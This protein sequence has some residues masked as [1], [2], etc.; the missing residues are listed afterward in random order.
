MKKKHS[1]KEKNEKNEKHELSEL[2][3]PYGDTMNDGVVQLSFTLPVECGARAK[4]AA[5]LYAQKLNFSEV[6]IAH[7]KKIADGF[8]YFVIYGKAEP[9]LDYSKVQATEVVTENLNF[10]TINEMIKNRLNRPLVVVGATIGSDAHTVGIDAIMNM[11]GYNQDYGLERY[12][13]MRAYN[14]GAQ[15]P[16][17]ELLKRALEVS[18]DVILVSQT[19]TQKDAH[20]RNFTEFIELL[21]AENMRKRFLLIAG[22]P[23]INHELAVELGYDAGFGPGTVPSQ[24]ASFIVT[25]IV[26]KNR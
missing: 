3:K 13:E 1:E 18:A 5:E 21:E 26:H 14:L 12:P 8:T 2:I 10:Y 25:K 19:V 4:K 23:R 15:I 17:E 24:V 11:K 20:I 16:A 22:G 6:S 7:Y 9:A